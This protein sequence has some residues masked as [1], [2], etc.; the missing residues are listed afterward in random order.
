MSK[1]GTCRWT[2]QVQELWRVPEHPH[3]R[4][5]HVTLPEGRYSCQW[6]NQYDH[7]KSPHWEPASDW[8]ARR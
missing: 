3:Q 7:D 5:E 1:I 2:H 4:E 8:P 6:L